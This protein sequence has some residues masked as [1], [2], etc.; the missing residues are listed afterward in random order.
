MVQRYGLLALYALSL[1]EAVD[2]EVDALGSDSTI[3]YASR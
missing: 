3:Q 2:P 1:A